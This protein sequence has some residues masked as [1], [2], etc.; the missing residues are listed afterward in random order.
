MVLWESS[1]RKAVFVNYHKLAHVYLASYPSLNQALKGFDSAGRTG[2]KAVDGTFA[3]LE[4]SRALF[5]VRVGEIIIPQG[6]I[7]KGSLKL[8]GLGWDVFFDIEISLK[9]IRIAGD[10]KN[11]I[12]I[13]VDNNCLFALTHATDKNRG[14]TMD[15]TINTTSPPHNCYFSGEIYLLGLSASAQFELSDTGMEFHETMSWLGGFKIDFVMD[16]KLYLNLS[17]S[18]ILD[19]AIP[20]FKVGAVPI[21]NV[22]VLKFSASLSTAVRWDH[23]EWQMSM[24]GQ[25]D[26]AQWDMGK[27]GPFTLDPDLSDFQKISKYLVN[28]I[29]DGFSDLFKGKISER[30]EEGVKEAVN[31]LKAVGLLAAKTTELLVKEFDLDLEEVIQEVGKT[32]ELEK[33]EIAKIMKDLGATAEQ[34]GRSGDCFDENEQSS[35]DSF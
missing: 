30:L 10:I 21:P 24:V 32:F 11:S 31:D 34:V 33:A 16:Y 26:L 25:M 20:P 28:Q 35:D 4:F 17:A 6:F 23:I 7:M 19:L 22:E 12:T 2:P 5:E 13:I 8:P 1:R 27:I 3:D 29:M 18:C 9:G 14:P 15:L